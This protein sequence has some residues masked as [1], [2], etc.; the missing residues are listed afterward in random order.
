MWATTCVFQGV[1]VVGPVANILP[2]NLVGAEMGALILAHDPPRNS[3]RQSM[4]SASIAEG[5]SQQWKLW[6]SLISASLP[7]YPSFAAFP[8]PMAPPTPN[9]PV[10]LQQL[11]SGGDK[12]MERGNLAAEMLKNGGR[13]DAFAPG[14]YNAIASAIEDTFKLWKQ[15]TPLLN[16]M[17]QG[18][19]PSF[20]PPYVPVGPVIGTAWGFGCLRGL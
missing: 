6:H 15:T 13:G 9:I 1:S 11:P 19:V 8:G 10:M 3:S 5:L 17:G 12:G 14:I 18:P 7:L 16:L 20:A 4:M 2:G